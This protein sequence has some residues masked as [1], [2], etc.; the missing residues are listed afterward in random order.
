MLRGHAGCRLRKRQPCMMRSATHHIHQ[1]K[2]GS[3]MQARTQPQ[4]A[5]HIS[6]QRASAVVT[7]SL[8]QAGH[9]TA[10]SDCSTV[11]AQRPLTMNTAGEQAY[12]F[13]HC[14]PLPVSQGTSATKCATLDATK[15]QALRSNATTHMLNNPRCTAV[16]SSAARYHNITLRWQKRDPRHRPLS[17]L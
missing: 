10:A 3:Q 11:T 14:M 5:L 4:G 16:R 13:C 2:H 9:K 17:N 7:W 15:M 1:T 6:S 12:I 8:F